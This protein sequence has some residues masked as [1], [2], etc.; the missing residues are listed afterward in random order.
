MKIQ[1]RLT[2]VSPVLYSYT[3]T[4]C[5]YSRQMFFLNP[6]NFVKVR[7]KGTLHTEINRAHFVSW[8]FR[9]R[10]KITKCIHEKIPLYFVCKRS[11]SRRKIQSSISFSPSITIFSL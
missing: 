11:L 6:E 1:F 4:V 8:C 2:H 9:I 7:Y 3:S 5:I 10:T